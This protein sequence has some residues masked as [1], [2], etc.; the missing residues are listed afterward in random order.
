MSTLPRLPQLV[1]EW[2][3]ILR[4]T[5]IEPPGSGVAEGGVHKQS[6]KVAVFH[7]FP[8]IKEVLERFLAE[9]H[10]LDV[11]SLSRQANSEP[12][13]EPLQLDIRFFQHP[14]LHLHGPS[15]RSAC[16]GRLM[17]NR[18]DSGHLANLAIR[19]KRSGPC[20]PGRG[21][22]F[23]CSAFGVRGRRHPQ[24]DRVVDNREPRSLGRDSC[25]LTVWSKPFSP[26]DNSFYI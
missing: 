17:T 20:L 5:S 2:L 14:V 6:T 22:G 10:L 9:R 8:Q 26:F 25:H 15:L 21:T 4:S 1:A 19:E 13:S 7:C 16:L 23:T 3:N 11:S 24:V 18:N 12:V